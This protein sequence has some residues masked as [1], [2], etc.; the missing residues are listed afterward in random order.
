M[1]REE[2]EAKFVRGAK[3]VFA[4]LWGWGEEHPEATFDEIVGKLSQERRA[5]MGEM[6]GEMLLQHGDGRYEEVA[7]PECGTKTQSNGRRTRTI[8]HAEGEV[9]VK[10]AHR[11]CP[12][13]GQG[14]FP[15]G[16]PSSVA[17]AK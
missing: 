10:R 2:A 14:I 17:R 3:E 9:K 13:C 1:E 12:D 16:P 7:C 11:L 6:L 4:T 8:V 15:P 5:L